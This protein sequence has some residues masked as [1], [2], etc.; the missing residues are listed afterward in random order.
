MVSA[1]ARLLAAR[2]RGRFDAEADEYLEFVTSGAEWMT[3]LISDLLEYARAGNERIRLVSVDSQ[4][5]FEGALRNLRTSLAETGA[6][7]QCHSLPPVLAAP[8][9]TQI[10]QNSIENGL[11]YRSQQAPQI[12]VSAEP[13]EADSWRFCV[14]DNGIGF[15]RA[16]AEELFQPFYRMHAQSTE[17]GTGMGLAICRRIIQQCGGEIWAHSEPGKGST[18]FFTLRASSELLAPSNQVALAAPANDL[19]PT[20]INRSRRNRAKQCRSRAALSKQQHHPDQ[21]AEVEA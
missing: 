12:Q 7:V 21:Y 17:P 19:P 3:E 13:G 4:F 9:L 16:H 14:A 6:V 20:R 5:C 18:F 11:R 10:F 1:Y 2:Y 8:Q 15:E